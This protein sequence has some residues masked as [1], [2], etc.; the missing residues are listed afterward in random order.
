[1]PVGQQV[2][3]GGSDELSLTDISSRSLSWFLGSKSGRRSALC[4][5]K[6]EEQEGGLHKQLTWQLAGHR[7]GPGCVPG[8]G[9]APS[10]CQGLFV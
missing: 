3:W 4:F 1:M 7:A 8:S 6:H 10:H 9:A 5:R 2:Q